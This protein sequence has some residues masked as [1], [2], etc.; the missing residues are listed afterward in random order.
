MKLDSATYR[1]S[2]ADGFGRNAM[3]IG[4]VGLAASAAGYF[5]NADQFFYSYLTAFIFWTSLGLGALFFTLLHHLTSAEWSVSIRRLTESVMMTLPF[6]VIFFVPVVFGAHTLYHWTHEEA[7]A[8]DAI[9]THKQP[10]LNMTFFLVRAA[11]YFA[12][13]FLLGRT[14][15]KWSRTQDDT[16]DHALNDKM[17]RFSAPGMILFALTLTFAAFDWV[18]SL[19]PHWYS[20]IFG[21]YMFVGSLLAALSFFSLILLMLRGKGVLADKITVEHYHDL[22]KLLFAFTVFW[23]YIAFSQYFLIWYGNIPE[24]TEFYHMRWEGSWKIISLLIVFGHFVLPFLALIARGAKRNL[25]W[26]RMM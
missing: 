22:G 20:T 8:A 3:I 18:M 23:T 14:L 16:G 2:G 1:L 13:W 5:V 12:V 10:Y 24:E 15:Y 9:L 11:V 17:K 21:V 26:L 25:G 7:V 6:M 19:N 4:V